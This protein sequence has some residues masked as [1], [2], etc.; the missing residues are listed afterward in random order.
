MLVVTLPILKNEKI[1]DPIEVAILT[2][3]LSELETYKEGLTGMKKVQ[4]QKI[5]MKFSV[6]SWFTMKLL[7]CR[8]VNFND[9][10]KSNRSSKTPNKQEVLPLSEILL[11][12]I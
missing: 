9:V 5:M 11:R 1:E 12:A 4:L 6:E 7:V 2:S 8:K 3:P 10:E